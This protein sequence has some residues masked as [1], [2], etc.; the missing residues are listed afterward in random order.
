MGGDVGNSTVA[1]AVS[2]FGKAAKA[3]LTDP[4]ISGQPEDQLRNPLEQLFE[5]GSILPQRKHTAATS[6]VVVQG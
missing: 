6:S 2:P 3:K 5:R 1:E 4:L